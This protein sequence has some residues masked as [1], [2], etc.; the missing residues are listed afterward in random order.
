MLTGHEVDSKV[1]NVISLSCEYDLDS[2]KK[3]Q[4]GISLEENQ[5]LDRSAICK[6][7][8]CKDLVEVNISNT[9]AN[10]EYRLRNS[11]FNH[12]GIL[13]DDFSVTKEKI[14]LNTFLSQA[15]FLETYLID[16]RTGKT[17]RTFY[18]YDD[19]NIYYDI[20][21]IEEDTNRKI[22][23]FNQNGRL[24]LKTLNLFSLEPLEIFHFEG[25]CLEGTGI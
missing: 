8:G 11:W 25:K 9:K 1:V 23:L 14:K 4:N 15:F 3:S 13:L 5:E 2:I 24:S 16:R 19:A 7:L 12:Q 10:N 21:K 18:R 20:K 22:P 17:K 6:Y